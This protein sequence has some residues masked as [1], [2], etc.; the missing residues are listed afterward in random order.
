MRTSAWRQNLAGELLAGRVKTCCI[1]T[2]LADKPDN[3]I[4]CNIRITWPAVLPWDRPFLDRHFNGV[5]DYRADD[6]FHFLF[7]QGFFIRHGIFIQ[8]RPG[9]CH[10]EC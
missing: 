2:T 8:L 5:F 3:A 1:I 10:E 6:R 7:Q 9:G 4:G